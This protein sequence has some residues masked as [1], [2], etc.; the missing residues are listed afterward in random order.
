MKK[1]NISYEDFEGVY[2]NPEDLYEVVRSKFDALQ[3]KYAR[4]ELRIECIPYEGI[5]M[6]F[7]GIELEKLKK[8][9]AE[10]LEK[11]RAEYERLKAKFG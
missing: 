6:A 8:E 1:E 3:N 5:S 7:Y 9:E 10:I 2:S 11:D 4:V